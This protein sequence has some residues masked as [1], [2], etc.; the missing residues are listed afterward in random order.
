[1]EE[2]ARIVVRESNCPPRRAPSILCKPVKFFDLMWSSLGT[3]LWTQ[4]DRGSTMI[5]NEVKERMDMNGQSMKGNFVD[6]IFA[7]AK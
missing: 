1:M 3:T 5:Q 2:A 6:N 4:C 7:S